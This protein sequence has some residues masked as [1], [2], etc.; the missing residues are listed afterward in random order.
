MPRPTDDV[1]ATLMLFVKGEFRSNFEFEIYSLSSS[2]NVNLVSGNADALSKGSLDKVHH[3]NALYVNIGR[4]PNSSVFL[5]VTYIDPNNISVS[6]KGDFVLSPE[7]ERVFKKIGSY[8]KKYFSDDPYKYV[9]YYFRIM[10]GY[11]KIT[12][13][14]S[15]AKPTKIDYKTAKR[16]RRRSVAEA[17][18]SKEVL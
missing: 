8:I 2:V 15:I 11:K 13:P 16:P 1:V 17:I 6:T 4:V 14:G 9:E 12:T 18:L 5:T 3:N 10:G 7:V